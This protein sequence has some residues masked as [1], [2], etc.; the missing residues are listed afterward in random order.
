MRNCGVLSHK[1][2]TP[3][4]V[5]WLSSVGP[6][7]P[8]SSRL[9]NTGVVPSDTEMD[10]SRLFFPVGW[11]ILDGV[12][13]R[14]PRVSVSGTNRCHPTSYVLNR[15]LSEPEF[16]WISRMFDV[17]DLNP[18]VIS[19]WTN[20]V[21]SKFFVCCMFEM[22]SSVNAFYFATHVLHRRY[23]NIRITFIKFSM[24]F[25]KIVTEGDLPP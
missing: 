21:M 17:L 12:W 5:G 20:K 7:D 16:G 15:S 6:S 24:C 19:K 10:D 22:F 1:R 18:S 23:T 11:S 9:S 8:K 2:G 13:G 3:T 25:T 14:D 4:I